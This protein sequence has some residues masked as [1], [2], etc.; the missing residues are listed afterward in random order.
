MVVSVNLAWNLLTLYGF[1]TLSILFLILLLLSSLCMTFPPFHNLLLQISPSLRVNY[2]AVFLTIWMIYILLPIRSEIILLQKPA[3]TKP[4]TWAFSSWWWYGRIYCKKS[5]ILMIV[6]K[7]LHS[8][9]YLSG[10][11][12]YSDAVWGC[13]F[14]IR[15]RK[16][17]QNG[18]L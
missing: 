7:T 3:S 14:V 15:L 6:E 13:Y 11:L 4:K 16:V 1:L 5:Q 17:R 2:V 8:T 12:E 10:Y 9:S 18:W